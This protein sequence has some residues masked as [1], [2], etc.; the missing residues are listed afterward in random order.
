[1]LNA[2]GIMRTV[3]DV[4]FGEIYVNRIGP[5]SLQGFHVGYRE[6]GIGGDD[7]EHG[8]ESYLRKKMVY[9]NY[10]GNPAGALMPYGC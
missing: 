10:G 2:A 6:S 8:L 3:T 7:G 9:V 5:E 1:M 4:E